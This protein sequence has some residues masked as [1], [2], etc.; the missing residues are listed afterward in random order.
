MQRSL[1]LFFG[2]ALLVPVFAQDEPK[3]YLGR[4]IAQTMHFTGA[5]WLTRHE[6]ER[7]EAGE[8]MR[9]E[10]KLKPGVNVCDLGCGN[11]YHTIP[12]A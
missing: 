1:F 9:D 3:T 7:E 2:L 6:R 4:R 11:G 10:L 8:V 5:E 12:I